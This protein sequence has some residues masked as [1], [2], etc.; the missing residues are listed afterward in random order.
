MS[1]LFHGGKRERG[2]TIVEVMISLIVISAIIV[3]AFLVS[4]A[5]TR[6]IRNS[7]EHTHALQLLQGQVELL[8]AY[9]PTD[10]TDPT[11]QSTNNFCMKSDGTPDNTAGSCALVDTFYTLVINRDTSTDS[12]KAASEGFGNTYRFTVTW[13]AQDG[14]TSKEQIFYRPATLS[15]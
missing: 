5:S 15:S 12:T 13:P 14:S 1:G 4:R 7:Q 8:R 3:G 2:D 10:P 6:N 11:L 9:I